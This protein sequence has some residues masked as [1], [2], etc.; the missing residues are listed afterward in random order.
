MSDLVNLMARVVGQFMQRW[1]RDKHLIVTSYNPVTHSVKGT[2]M[3]EGIM[4]GWIPIRVAGASSQGISHVVAPS[5]GDQANIA[6][7]EGD[8]EAAH[9]T[10]FSH[11][12]ID[13]PPMAA[14]GTMIVKHN[15]SGVL[16]AM[17][18]TG[19]V[20]AAPG[21]SITHSAQTITHTATGQIS[22][23]AAGFT[24]TG[25]GNLV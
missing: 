21:Q 15:P 10:G 11:N 22:M 12:D 1:A 16:Q 19:H 7:A 6:Y 4:S 24:L 14:C 3:P 13:Q 9:V 8:P 25:G 5:I 18:G 23:T 20:F 17:S 2:L